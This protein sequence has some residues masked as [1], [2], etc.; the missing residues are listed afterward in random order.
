MVNSTEKQ[1]REDPSGGMSG[2]IKLLADQI[3]GQ[4][5]LAARVGLGR[6]SIWEYI[7]GRRVP[8]SGTLQSIAAL[9]PCSL[10]WLELGVGDPPKIDPE[11]TLQA[12]RIVQGH[13][14]RPIASYGSITSIVGAYEALVRSSGAIEHKIDLKGAIERLVQIAKTQE[15]F[16]TMERV[17]GPSLALEVRA[18]RACPSLELLRSLSE[19]LESKDGVGIR[20]E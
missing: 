5:A 13:R 9:Y 16:S 17:L 20:E 6:H 8:P 11:R 3:G 15:G 10:E 14:S 4:G 1:K 19:S 12:R 2:R 7:T 18:G